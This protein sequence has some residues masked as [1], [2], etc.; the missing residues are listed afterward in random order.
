LPWRATAATVSLNGGL[1]EFAIAGGATGASVSNAAGASLDGATLRLGV[2][3]AANLLSGVINLEGVQQA[4]NAIVVNGNA[5]VLKS[6]LQAPN[7]S[8][9]SNRVD[10]YSGARIQ[11]AVNIAKTGTPGAGARSTCT[12]AAMPS[13]SCSTRPT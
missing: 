8:G 4:S 1:Y 6:A 5:V 3:D 7:V 10:V 2:G 9:N 11:D 12:R 13:R